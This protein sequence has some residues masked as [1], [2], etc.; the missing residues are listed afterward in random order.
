[1]SLPLLLL[2]ESLLLTLL[3]SLLRLLLPASL[4]LLVLLLLLL[5]LPLFGPNA[6]LRS[7]LL[8]VKF[9]LLCTAGRWCLLLLLM[10]PKPFPVCGFLRHS[11]LRGDLES[12]CMLLV[13]WSKS[14][15]SSDHCSA[16]LSVTHVF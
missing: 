3:N 8:P 11:T 14:A 6:F 9:E 12:C 7:L 4:G 13:W 16:C 5:L 2:P 10:V 1:L 15:S